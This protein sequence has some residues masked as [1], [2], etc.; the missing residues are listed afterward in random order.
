MSPTTPRRRRVRPGATPRAPCARHMRGARHIGW[1]GKGQYPEYAL[2]RAGGGWGQR[3]VWAAHSY[4]HSHRRGCGREFAS[5]L[6]QS[7]SHG[8][9]THPLPG[10]RRRLQA[11]TSPP[12]CRLCGP[13][14]ASE[15]AISLPAPSPPSRPSCLLPPLLLTP[16]V[17]TPAPA[18]LALCHAVLAVP[19]PTS[20]LPH[21]RIVLGPPRRSCKRPV[22]CDT[23]LNALTGTHTL[24]T[25]THTHLHSY[26]LAQSS[27]LA[28]ASCPS[29]HTHTN[30]DT[31]TGPPC[32]SLP[33]A[34]LCYKTGENSRVY[35]RL[36]GRW[37]DEDGHGRWKARLKL[38]NALLSTGQAAWGS[39]MI[40]CR[41]RCHKR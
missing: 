1:Q 20:V 40:R 29:G 30:S 13:Q 39:G 37:T 10:T 31:R 5:A 16:A 35:A 11:R 27:P 3:R 18:V 24:R 17:A 32:P 26:L 36:C 33:A 22:P 19:T 4:K 12:R 9:D 8:A 15:P 38:K 34:A 2:C 41:K 21:G 23:R 14:P 28:Q 7:P 6:T 25:Q